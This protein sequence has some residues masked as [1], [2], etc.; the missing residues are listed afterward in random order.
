MAVSDET[1][2]I[3]SEVECMGLAMMKSLMIIT[4]C[5]KSFH[6]HHYVMYIWVSSSE[7]E[8]G[9]YDAIEQMT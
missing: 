1:L 6:V 7:K 3:S 9:F 5:D 4:F 8:G 2:L